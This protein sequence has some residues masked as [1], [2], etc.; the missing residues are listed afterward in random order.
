MRFYGFR[1]NEKEII[2]TNQGLI[3]Y[4]NKEREKEGVH[5]PHLHQLQ[6]VLLPPKR[7]RMGKEF[8]FNIL[9]V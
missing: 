9:F 7:V 5:L 6:F 8:H 3:I 1:V 2:E 4:K